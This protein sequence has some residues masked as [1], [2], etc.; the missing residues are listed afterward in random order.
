[1]QVLKRFCLLALAGIIVMAFMACSG[2]QTVRPFEPGKGKSLGCF[3]DN[4]VDRDLSG[5]MVSTNTMTTEQCITTCAEKGFTYAGTQYS[6]QCLCGNSYGK[7]GAAN[8][9]NMK[10]AGNQ[11]QTC[12]GYSANSVYGLK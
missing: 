7:Y 12:G 4:A 10:C 2:V 8:N 11:N 1:M 6:S 5:L 3:K 9:C